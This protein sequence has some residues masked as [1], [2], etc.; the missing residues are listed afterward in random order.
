MKRFLFILLTCLLLQG[1]GMERF[2]KEPV[3]IPTP[4]PVGFSYK[5]TSKNTAYLY[6]SSIVKLLSYTSDKHV[7][8]NMVPVHFKYSQ[9]SNFAW[10]EPEAY[11]RLYKSNVQLDDDGN[12]VEG[13][14]YDYVE[15]EMFYL[16]NEQ[17][18]D[19]EGNWFINMCKHN[20]ESVMSY[21]KKAFAS[22]SA[23][24]TEEFVKIDS[25]FKQTSVESTY[26]L[27][28][29]EFPAPATEY[30]VSVLVNDST[31]ILPFKTYTFDIEDTG[32]L[33]LNVKLLSAEYADLL[34]VSTYKN[35]DYTITK[36][37][38][39]QLNNLPETCVNADD[40]VDYVLYGDFSHVFE[41][42]SRPITLPSAVEATPTPTTEIEPEAEFVDTTEDYGYSYSTEVQ[43]YFED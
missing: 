26:M 17:Y 38:T 36:E 3:V 42:E 39:R 41:T 6:N 15:Y 33:V 4:E 25:I 9:L 1:C 23:Y 8:T 20:T 5:L 37:L 27:S 11:V 31:F 16:T 24:I 34:D 40:I 43:G 7:F 29:L 21:D 12:L 35:S 19:N 28:G 22:Y 18:K 2:Y 30:S 13:T 32:K 14:D 10:I